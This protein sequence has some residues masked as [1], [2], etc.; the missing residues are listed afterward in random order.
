M[1]PNQRITSTFDASSD[2][3]EKLANEPIRI[4]GRKKIRKQHGLLYNV[5]YT[6]LRDCWNL[7]YLTPKGV[8]IVPTLLPCQSIATALSTNYSEIGV[9][10]SRG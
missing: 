9:H 2:T 4:H 10:N 7:T 1:G 6:E 3:E 5:V 8:S